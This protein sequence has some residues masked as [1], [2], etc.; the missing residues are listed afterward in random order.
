[1]E[2]IEVMKDIEGIAGALDGSIERIMMDIA[3]EEGETN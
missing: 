3:N 2:D 1:M